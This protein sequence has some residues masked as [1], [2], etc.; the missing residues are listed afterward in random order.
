MLRF[1]MMNSS[2]K[3]RISVT[4]DADLLDAIDRYADNRSAAVEE[5]LRLW[6]KQ[7]VENQLRVFY[8][9]QSLEEREREEVWAEFAHGEMEAAIDSGSEGMND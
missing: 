6:Q 7:Q 4:I 9:Q 1:Y 2:P 3:Q 5:G 8:R